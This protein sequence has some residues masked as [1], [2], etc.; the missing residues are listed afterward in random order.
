MMCVSKA[1]GSAELAL[2]ALEARGQEGCMGGPA[3]RLA[4][5]CGGGWQAACG[6]GKPCLTA[7]INTSSF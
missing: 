7:P 4:A 5:M 3:S 6:A 2:K 1:W